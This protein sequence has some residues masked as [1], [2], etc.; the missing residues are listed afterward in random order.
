MGEESI[1]RPP[2]WKKASITAAHSFRNSMSS[3]T[4]KVIHVPRPIAGM[5][6]PVE[7]IFLASKVLLCARKLIGTN[8]RGA[9]AP[10]WMTLRR[11]VFMVV[12]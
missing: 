3:L 10:N 9:A 4:L 1:T 5:A 6:S 7:G 12:I 8:K 2:S 11:V